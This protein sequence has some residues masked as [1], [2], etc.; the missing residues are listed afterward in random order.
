MWQNH[1]QPF[2]LFLALDMAAGLAHLHSMGC[3]PSSHHALAPR[4]SALY[5]VRSTA[6]T[7]SGAGVHRD[8]KPKN[9][10]VTHLAWVGLGW[11]GL[12]YPKMDPWSL[13]GN[14][15]LALSGGLFRR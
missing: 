7:G 1:A 5:G 9:V 2:L 12:G 13:Q 15:T 11:V 14:G 10:L 3:E 8:I 4:R 6:H